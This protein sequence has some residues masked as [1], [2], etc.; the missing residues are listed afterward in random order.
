VLSLVACALPCGGPAALA[1]NPDRPPTDYWGY[2]PPAS[3]TESV[4]SEHFVIHYTSANGDP[5]AIL[6]RRAQTFS[7]AAERAYALEVDEWHFPAPVDDGDGRTDVYVYSDERT[8]G[9]ALTHVDWPPPAGTRSSSAWVSIPRGAGNFIVA[10]E[11]FHVLQFARFVYWGWATEPSAVWAHLNV[12]GQGGWP[13]IYADPWDALDC[14][15][16]SDPY[17]C[18]G[19]PLGYGRWIFFEYLSERYGGPDFVNAVGRRLA[20]RGQSDWHASPTQALEDAL[21]DNGTSVASTF[22][23]YVRSTIAA[24]WTLPGI[25]HS[26]PSA[27]T[28]GTTRDAQTKTVAV[29][30]L[31]ARYVDLIA[32]GGDE[33]CEATTLHLEVTVPPGVD[34]RP[35]LRHFV[36]G[37]PATVMNVDADG[38]ARAE[39]PW[40]RCKQPSHAIVGLPNGSA[41]A[42]D[43]QFAVKFWETPDPSA[44]PIPPP[45][46]APAA[47][48]QPP[49][50]STEEPGPAPGATPSA[51][52]L[53]LRLSM[54]SRVIVSRRTRTLMVRLHS[55]QRAL[56]RLTLAPGVTRVLELRAGWNRTR[57]K[58]PRS[59]HAGRHRVEV[60]SIVPVGA[61]AAPLT[62][63][64]VLR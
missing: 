47:P 50:G 7:D 16:E 29:G 35:V 61:S 36:E 24:D 23:G 1:S 11:L 10:H 37:S 15:S 4:T 9:A 22:V 62:V 46:A 34:T 26:L 44:D 64:I 54:P 58:L 3:L 63:R 6:P 55:S 43:Q 2:T 52:S 21:A 56:V 39:L 20:A 12:T 33:G 42:D 49:A 19:D 25:G 48:E 28:Y 14:R 51:P 31:A 60:R 57:L 17:A 32:W 38:V 41:T 5:N 18:G 40:R 59:L 8:A 53:E 13:G 30:H 45:V 27:E